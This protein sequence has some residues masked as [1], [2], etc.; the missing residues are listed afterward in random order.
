MLVA[1]GHSEND[2]AVALNIRPGHLRQH[3][4]HELDNGAAMANAPVIKT[5]YD[6]ARTK[7][8][9]RASTLWAKARMGWRDGETSQPQTGGLNIIIHS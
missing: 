5:I 3:Y 8:N 1:G 2:I 7:G 4:G 9:M 6:Q